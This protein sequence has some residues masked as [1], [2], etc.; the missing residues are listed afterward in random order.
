MTFCWVKFDKLCQKADKEYW[1]KFK[2]TREEKLLEMGYSKEFAKK[3]K[4]ESK[5]K[6][7]INLT[8]FL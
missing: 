7:E 1:D 4:K 6:E 3:T 5:G 8:T 2:G